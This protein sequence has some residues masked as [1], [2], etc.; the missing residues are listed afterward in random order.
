MKRQFLKVSTAYR[1][2]V[3]A[4]IGISATVGTSIANGLG[5]AKPTLVEDKFDLPTNQRIVTGEWMSRGFAKPTV[6]VYP[7]GWAKNEHAYPYSLI[8]T[9]IA[10]R[11][12]YIIA[13]QRVV[14]EPGDELY[15]PARAVMLAKNIHDGD[16]RVL[17]S[18]R[19]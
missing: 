2:A 9:P 8:I 6:K 10:G 7:R 5:S 19:R 1:I 14:I 15:Y 16:T 4:I 12:E 17:I 13:D 18:M 11:M 3:L